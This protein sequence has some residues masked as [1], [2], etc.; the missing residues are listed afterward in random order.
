MFYPDFFVEVRSGNYFIRGDVPVGVII[1]PYDLFLT[2]Q[3][4]W[5]NDSEITAQFV[6][7]DTNIWYDY[8]AGY[9]VSSVFIDFFL[10]LICL[11]WA[12]WKIYGLVINKN[13][14]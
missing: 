9:R 6:E 4:K 8:S 1:L 13:L 2:M 12:S 5:N 3:I 11:F 7:F 10:I 14:V